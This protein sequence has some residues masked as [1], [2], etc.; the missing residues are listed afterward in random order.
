MSKGLG[1]SS[2]ERFGLQ[3]RSIALS[4]ASDRLLLR[5]FAEYVE[6][7]AQYGLQQ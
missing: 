4:N 1:N 2:S 7:V 3:C 5:I 6:L